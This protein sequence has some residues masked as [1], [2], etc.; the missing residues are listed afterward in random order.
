M[1][2]H[3]KTAV[4]TTVL[5]IQQDRKQGKTFAEMLRIPMVLMIHSTYCKDFKM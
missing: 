2:N 5:E 1:Y 3:I 4:K